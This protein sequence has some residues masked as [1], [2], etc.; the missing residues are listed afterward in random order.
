MLAE[1]LFSV[2][3]EPRKFHADFGKEVGGLASGAS[4]P[5]TGDNSTNRCD[6]RKPNGLPSKLSR[7]KYAIQLK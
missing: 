7:L 1:A 2:T 3:L 5:N 4:L 6:L